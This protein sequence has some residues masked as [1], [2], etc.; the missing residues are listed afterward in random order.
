[1]HDREKC[2][3]IAQRATEIAEEMG[4]DVEVV[5]GGDHFPTVGI[6]TEVTIRDARKISS[7]SDSEIRQAIE[8]LMQWRFETDPCAS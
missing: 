4:A 7:D 5:V 6:V 1:M 2:E 8:E 3:A